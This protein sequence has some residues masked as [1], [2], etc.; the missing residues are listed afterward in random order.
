[1][2]RL[3]VPRTDTCESVLG[4]RGQVFD[5]EDRLRRDRSAIVS[6]GGSSVLSLRG[7]LL[8]RLLIVGSSPVEQRPS[9]IVEVA[10]DSGVSGGCFSAEYIRVGGD[11]GSNQS[12][13]KITEL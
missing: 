6:P 5:G 4:H 7:Q 1:M 8:D 3:V 9:A 12:W 13:C 10:C 2:L 11:D